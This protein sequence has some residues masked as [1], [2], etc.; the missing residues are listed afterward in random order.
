M[1]KYEFLYQLRNRLS[2]LPNEDIERSI[3]YYSEIID[4]RIEDGLS[5]E[6]AV[7][8]LGSAEEIAAQIIAE[9]PLPRLVKA[10]V[11]PKR[12]LKAW[13]I[14]LLILGSPLW[15]PLIAAA[16]SIVL[17]AYLVIW[18]VVLVLYSV[19]LAFAACALCGIFSIFVFVGTGNA[20]QG[21]FML[22]LGL[23]CAGIAILLFFGFNQVTKC[24][25]VLSKNILL[26]IKSCFIRKGE[27][28]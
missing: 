13:E 28:K 21:V 9:I 20:V 11:K 12:E 16:V 25:W 24:I 6:D 7:S 27:R 17:S 4:D 1:K 26:G 10:R 5:E 2:G 22:G 19:D 15:L 23:I 14:L 3:D 8:A 18:A